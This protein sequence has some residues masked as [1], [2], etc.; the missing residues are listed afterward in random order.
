MHIN[1][2]EKTAP[3]VA[4]TTAVLLAIIKLIAGLMSGSISVLSSAIDS[5]LDCIV[6]GFNYFALRKSQ[7]GPNDKF[8]FGYGKLEALVAL[9]EGAFIIGIGIFICIQSI[10]KFYAK[11][12]D[13]NIDVGLYVMILS[14]V[15]TGILILYLNFVSKKSGNLI[16]KTDALHY[17]TDFLTNLAI[18]ITL[19]I[20]KFTG[21]TIIDAIFG[22]IVSIYIVFSAIKIIKEGIYTLLDGAIDEN[23]VDDITKFIISRDDVTDFHDLRTRKSAKT[24]FF[25]IHMVF[26]PGISL[27]KAHAIGDEVEHYIQTKYDSYSWIINLHFD[28]IDDSN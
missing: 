14:F 13:F 3:I 18:I 24:C 1:K 16:I 6:S 19:I 22:I 12:H 20:I 15:I 28:P 11:N 9:L 26:H 23:I 4:G 27:S 25:Y 21:L 17:Q 7:Q 5:M 8:N 10:Q 2:L